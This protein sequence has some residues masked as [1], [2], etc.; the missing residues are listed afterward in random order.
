MLSE[1]KKEIKLQ[2][3]PKNF[4]GGGGYIARWRDDRR[5]RDRRRGRGCDEGRAAP[6]RRRRRTGQGH[7]ANIS[8]LPEY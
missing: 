8:E 3:I 6:H 2:A 7:Q 1:T 5:R 4:P